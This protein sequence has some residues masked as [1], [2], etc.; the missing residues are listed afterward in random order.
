M[1]PRTPWTDLRDTLNSGE[2]VVKYVEKN[3]T[4]LKS[5][6]KNN[7]YEELSIFTITW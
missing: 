6:K 2:F 4:C 7:L 5:K 1:D 3:Q